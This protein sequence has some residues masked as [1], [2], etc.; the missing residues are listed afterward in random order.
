MH[1]MLTDPL[2]LCLDASRRGPVVRLGRFRGHPVYQIHEP[3]LI[4]Q[5]LRDLDSYSM[6]RD[7][8]VLKAVLGTSLFVLRDDDWVVRRK[9]V[10]PAFHGRQMPALG[11]ALLPVLSRFRESWLDRARRGESLDLDRE[12]MAL[13]QRLIARA[14]LDVDLDGDLDALCDGVR[15]ALAYGHRRRWSQRPLPMGWPTPA[16][17]KFR[18]LL[19]DLERRMGSLLAAAE[20]EPSP[21]ESFLQV[22]RNA[23][24]SGN[25]RLSGR[26]IGREAL[27]IFNA[28]SVTTSAALTWTFY[29]LARH[30]EVQDR[31]RREIREVLA[32]EPPGADVVDRLPF[33][34]TAVQEVMRLHP[35][36]WLMTR[37]ASR[38]TGLGGYRLPAGSLLMISQYALHRDERWWPDPERFDPARFAA[39]DP[40]ELAYRYFPFGFGARRCLGERIAW[41][42]I[43]MTV[44]VTLASLRVSLPS[45][46]RARPW[47]LQAL[48]PRDPVPLRVEALTHEVEA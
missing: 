13:S 32:G 7:A 33:L 37:R 40:H 29:R 25:G 12:M 48:R 11:D 42:E 43:L 3:H 36:T 17:L 38:E 2:G 4:R 16:N 27:M 14:M 34:T 28:G 10:Q 41:I 9:I 30:P 1:R 20:P 24:R 45:G 6:T 15:F 5:V 26:Q 18:R 39:A 22:L 23:A 19:G 21:R 31:A 44:A 8:D 46:Y 35:P 47:T